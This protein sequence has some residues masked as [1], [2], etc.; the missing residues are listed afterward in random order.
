MEGAA[1]TPM[2]FSHF[3]DMERVLFRNLQ[4]P[5]TVRNYILDLIREQQ[6]AVSQVRGE[7]LTVPSHV[8]KGFFS[9]LVQKV[10]E[11]ATYYQ[12]QSL[13]QKADLASAAT[14]ISNVSVLFT[15]RDWSVTGTLSCFSGA[16]IGLVAPKC[17]K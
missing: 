13:L 1:S 14:V 12:P 5:A 10:G 4:F 11:L 15:T 7:K 9:G 17:P 16:M 8:T 6:Q 3:L 2:P